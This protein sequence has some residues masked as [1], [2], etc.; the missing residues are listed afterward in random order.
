MRSVREF[1]R[2]IHRRSMWQVMA[3]Y[4]GA[5]WA[6]LE[7]VDLLVGAAG[8]PIWLPSIALTALIV[9]FPLVLATAL[10]RDPHE[11]QGRVDSDA[12]PSATVVGVTPRALLAGGV[13]V[14]VAGWSIVAGASALGSD[15]HSEPS[16]EAAFPGPMEAVA[17]DTLFGALAGG[18]PSVA[19]LPF[20]NRSPDPDHAFFADGVHDNVVVAL[21]RIASLD[22]RSQR[23]VARFRET[24]L[25]LP[26]I[27]GELHVETLLE[28]T[29]HRSGRR[30]RIIAHLVDPATGSPLWSQSYDRDLDDV[31]AVQTDVAMRVAAALEATLSPL[32]IARLERR[33]TSHLSA[34]DFYLRGREAYARFTSES[35]DEARRLF[36]EAVSIDPSFAAAWAGI[37]DTFLQRI[38]FYG[39]SKALADSGRAM[40]EKAVTLDPDLPEAYKTLA[41][42]HSVDEFHYK[43]LEANLR[44]VELAP[45]YADAVNNVGFA[46]FF[47]GDIPRALPW[48]ERSLALQPNLVLLRSNVGAL[49][50]LAGDTVVARRFLDEALAL[51][52][53]NPGA[54]NW[55]VLWE[56][57][58][59][60][61]TEARKLADVFLQSRP[62]ALAH[63]RVALAAL[64][65][66]EPE[67]ALAYANQA[68]E[69]APGARLIESYAIDNIRGAALAALDR[70]DRAQPYLMAVLDEAQASIASGADGWQ[71]V[72]ALATASAALG[73][74]DALDH[75]E[76]ANEIGFSFL[77]LLIHSPAFDDLRGEARFQSIVRSAYERIDRDRRALNARLLT[78]RA[79]PQGD[80]AEV[81]G[82]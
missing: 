77:P 54:R 66:G 82:S 69:L 26:E 63:G 67:T 75:F 17:A 36:R 64:F 70:H 68:A 29:V 52:A 18:R 14:A 37:G 51:D 16:P 2:E 57:Y 71:P 72:W 80:C 38:Q 49:H 35:N 58:R 53:H 74:P 9:G 12:A 34:Y 41:F 46:Y 20:T 47:L 30:I 24:S 28:G 4:L 13:I 23:S 5:C 73:H 65:A 45:D 76:A 48:V 62:D 3:V 79:C 50:L 59:G 78:T 42:A 55:R 11:S 21:S 8:L 39:G 61:P 25:S 40:A 10:I 7:V 32:E 22:V 56:V 1:F 27:A 33:P 6:A 44:A 81:G 60:D 31:F 15:D 19:V 43:S